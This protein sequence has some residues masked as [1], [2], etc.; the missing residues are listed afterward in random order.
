[1]NSSYKEY[2]SKNWV[3]EQLS[4]IPEAP[5]KVSAL[6]NDAG[7]VTETEVSAAVTEL[8]DAAPEALNTLNELAAALD[9]DP[10]F[11]ATIATN[12][13]KVNDRVD[14][15]ENMQGMYR[16]DFE[17]PVYATYPDSFS[18]ADYD[19]TKA[20]VKISDYI[21]ASEFQGGSVHSSTYGWTSLSLAPLR[22]YVSNRG[23]T[24]DVIGMAGGEIY[25][26]WMP[27]T[28]TYPCEYMWMDGGGSSAQLLTFTEPGIYG[29][30]NYYGK[31]YHAVQKMS[32][33]S[34]IDA[35]Q[36]EL[37]NIKENYVP[38]SEIESII[39]NYLMNNTEAMA[40]IATNYNNTVTVNEEW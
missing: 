25:V 37:D 33:A 16:A 22:S 2:A 21:P 39:Q 10:N 40:S 18:S 20:Y 6:E 15:L 35:L 1:M 9:D 30:N 23:E 24:Y 26:M 31:S 13:G 29:L 7:Y 14:T 32:L 19:A 38:R 3:T 34:K 28:F 11:A 5:K 4:T 12:I 8:I 27:T 17:N 36:V